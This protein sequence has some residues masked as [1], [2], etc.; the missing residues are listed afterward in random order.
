MARSSLHDRGASIDRA[1]RLF[2]ARGYHATSLKDLEQALD[3]RPGS[4]Y[5]AFGS[6][7]GLFHRALDR[8][9]QEMG[10]EFGT[11]IEG[12][13]SPVEGIRR[14]L[15]E[16]AR[17]CSTA[18]A[19]NEDG[20]PMPGCMLVKTILEIGDDDPEIR[21]RADQVLAEVESKLAARLTQAKALGELRADAQPRRLARLV[22]AQIMG[23]RAF[24][25]RAVSARAVRELGDDMGRVLDPYLAPGQDTDSS[26]LEH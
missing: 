11:V 16:V 4:I 21:N 10:E 26:R 9:S 23:L 25:Q 24:A 15:R 1:L 3:M 20:W 8:Y 5:A 13:A 18:G 22:Q 14:Y 17:A 6:K 19:D 7:A 2:W 12:A